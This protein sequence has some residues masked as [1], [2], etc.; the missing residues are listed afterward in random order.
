MRPTTPPPAATSV[1]VVHLRQGYS[2]A[3]TLLGTVNFPFPVHTTPYGWNLTGSFPLVTLTPGA[4]HV[5]S[6][7]TDGTGVFSIEA[8]NSWLSL[9]D[10]GPVSVAVPPVDPN[11]PWTALTLTSPWVWAGGA[12]PKVAWRK[13]GDKVEIRGAVNRPSQLTNPSTSAVCTL[14]VGARPAYNINL[15]ATGV[16]SDAWG[17]PNYILV[18]TDGVVAVLRA[19]E[20]ATRPDI[21]S[22]WDT[23]FST[24][25]GP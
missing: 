21:L 9:D 11:P 10:V 7:N 13:V 12:N 22:S 4:N 14:P 17:A 1:I 20:G 3:G 8:T 15:P 23:R 25:G 24:T 6:I 18:Q 2:V 16:G 5:L 19:A